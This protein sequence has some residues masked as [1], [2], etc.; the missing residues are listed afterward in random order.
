MTTNGPEEPVDPQ[1]TALEQEI[2][3]KL[4]DWTEK[5]KDQVTQLTTPRP[6]AEGSA[7]IAEPTSQFF[8]IT[9][10]WLD[11]LAVGPFQSVAPGGP[12][13]PHR[14]IRRANPPC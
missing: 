10:Q 9:Y 11:L 4:E 3:K 13:L 1:V 6:Q 8:G 12:F 7:E 5:Y 14:I 2:P